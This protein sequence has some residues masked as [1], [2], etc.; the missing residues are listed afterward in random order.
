MAQGRARLNLTQDALR[1]SEAKFHQIADGSPS[2]WFIADPHTRKVL[3]ISPAYET[4]FQQPSDPLMQDMFAWLEHVHPDDRPM[5]ESALTTLEQT[6]FDTECRIVRS[7]GVR[8]IRSRVYPVRASDGATIRLAGLAEDVT[9]VHHRDEEL[10]AAH[11]ALQASRDRLQS[12]V[13]TAPLP[14]IATDADGRVVVWS[15][16]ATRMLGWSA[17]EVLDRSLPASL[18]TKSCSSGHDETW[19]SKEGDRIPVEV[20]DSESPGGLRLTI[21]VDI[22]ERLAAQAQALKLARLEETAA[23]KTTFLNMA[24][25]ELATPLTPLQ[26]QIA[27]LIAAPRDPEDTQG[28]QLMERNIKRL[29]AL[30][31]DLLDAAR[32]QS[33]KLRINPTA[34]SVRQSLEDVYHSFEAKARDEGITL[35]LDVE[36]DPYVRADSVRIAQVMTN[37]V[38]NAVKFTPRGGTVTLHAHS[39]HGCAEITVRDTGLGMTLEQRQQLFQPFG[40]VHSLQQ[41][42]QKARTGTGLGLYICRGILEEHGGSVEASSPGPGRGTTFTMRLPRQAIP[43]SVSLAPPKPA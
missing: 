41:K 5:V 13:D 34:M 14:V 32:L 39:D 7:D 6:G 2:I 27:S 28:L 12:I 43:S 24:A 36:G 25:H 40:Q 17:Q 19:T 4:T 9:E 38:H 8:W 42:P 15:P 23:F 31:Q 11:A 16:A 33:G 3:Y 26:M 21:L 10:R 20:L 22:R 18:R 30:V 37:L 1:Q 29:G 35:V